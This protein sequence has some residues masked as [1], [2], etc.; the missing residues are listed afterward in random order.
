MSGLEIAWWLLFFCAFGL[1]VGSF[2]NV[3][4][5]RVPRDI[6]LRDPVWS[7]CPGCGQRIAWYDNLPLVSYLNLRGRCRG[8]RM[9]ISP[10][11]PLVELLGALT[12]VVLFDAFFVAHSHPG[13]GEYFARE[14]MQL[15][16]SWQLSEDWP[17]YIAHVIL[18]A[19]LLA[20]SAIDIEHYWVDVRFTWFATVAGFVLHGLWSP[21]HTDTWQRPGTALAA[22]ALIATLALVITT[23][24]LMR[25]DRSADLPSGNEFADPPSIDF[26]PIFAGAPGLADTETAP[27]A[28]ADVAPAR[29][30][31]VRLAWWLAGIALVVVLIG[32]WTASTGWGPQVAPAGRWLGVVGLLFALIVAGGLPQRAADHEI[33]AAIES[34]RHD[35][36]RVA[37]GE[38]GMLAPA[39]LFGGFTCYLIATQADWTGPV[40]SVLGWSP[41][42]DWH[43]LNGLATAATGFIIGG[44]IG[45]FVRI[46]ATLIMGR[47]AF[48]TGDI[49]MMAAAGCVAG[50]PVVL[51]GFVICSVLALAGWLMLVPFKRARA[52]PLGPWLSIAFFIV[53][54][55][56]EPLMEWTPVRNMVEV[57]G[58]PATMF[59]NFTAPKRLP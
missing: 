23:W 1:S 58:D 50:W 10:R 35:A 7:F 13:I 4:I 36:R 55:F 47:E 27:S 56:Y 12:A 30:G 21:R 5:H 11:Y 15:A 40:E 29:I 26:A 44:G 42:R 43:P 45:W 41:T 59:Q 6:S 14:A 3:V 31:A 57:F 22:G 39:I 20:M 48:G 16:T 37:V 52:I 54:I 34:E 25:R 53:V 51:L 28:E 17:I 46:T 33:I 9:R 38:L 24:W 8:C 18:F 32:A 2:L 19:A 49:H